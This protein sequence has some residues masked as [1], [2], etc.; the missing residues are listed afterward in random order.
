[1]EAHRRPSVSP[2]GTIAAG[3]VERRPALIAFLGRP[4]RLG[5]DP[6]SGRR[7]S[8]RHRGG[9]GAAEIPADPLQPLTGL[10]SDVGAR[11][12]R[13]S[14]AS[15]DAARSFVSSAPTPACRSASSP[16]AARPVRRPTSSPAA[17]ASRSRSRRP[18]RCWSCR[19]APASGGESRQR[20]R[21]SGHRRARARMRLLGADPERRRRAR[22]AGCPARS[23]TSSASG[24]TGAR[25]FPTYERV[26]YHDAWPG[27]DVDYYGNR[28]RLEYDFRLAPGADPERIALASPARTAIRI[29]ANGDLVLESAAGAR[30][31]AR[32]GRLPANRRRAGRGRRRLRPATASAPSACASAPTTPRGRWS[33]T[34]C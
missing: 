6:L 22:S 7:R 11:R 20:R 28:G 31:P 18:R 21:P 4:A 5:A 14:R 12:R 16:T 27:I 19:R 3:V 1:M 8:V 23:T 26:R 2:H 24:A 30:A 29:A 9:A 33:S 15:S 25:A 34:R 10:A 13:P 32:P 17:P